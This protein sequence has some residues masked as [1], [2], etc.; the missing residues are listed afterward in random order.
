M[1]KLRIGSD[2]PK[3]SLETTEGKSIIISQYILKQCIVFYCLL[4]GHGD[5]NALFSWKGI[6]SIEYFLI[7]SGQP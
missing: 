1:K 3:I 4:E 6:E 5:L 2:F 7:D